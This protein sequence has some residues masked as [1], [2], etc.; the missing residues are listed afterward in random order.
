MNIRTIMYCL[1]IF[2]FTSCDFS[3]SS[4]ELTNQTFKQVLMVEN[5]VLVKGLNVPDEFSMQ[6]VFEES[7][8]KIKKLIEQKANGN[9]QGVKS[10]SFILDG[11]K[12]YKIVTL[13]Q[14]SENAIVIK[15]TAFNNP[16][17]Y[18]ITSYYLSENGKLVDVIQMDSDKKIHFSRFVEIK[19]FSDSL[20][21][22]LGFEI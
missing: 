14:R 4:N 20:E 16:E 18:Y 1:G 8:L 7:A 6:K 13:Y 22:E 3:P 11:E 10:Y 17:N 21:K 15:K 5:Q 12:I 9:I 2:L 19:Q